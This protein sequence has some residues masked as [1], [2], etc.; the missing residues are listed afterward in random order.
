MEKE[1]KELYDKLLADAKAGGYHLS[2]DTEFVEQLL[3]GMLANGERYGYMACP[4]R[5]ASGSKEE[6]LDLICP[7]DYRDAD[8][9]EYDMCYCGLYVTERVLRQ[10]A[11]MQSIPDRRPPGGP[12]KGENLTR[13]V[14]ALPLPVYRCKVCGYLCAMEH[15]PER[16]PICK[17][18][19]DRFER[20]I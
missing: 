9:Q 5:L 3:A 10:E 7:C 14:G 15:P 16:C 12:H 8:L 1:I 13:G 19:A 17:V 18:T 6:D 20:F 2:P 4:C 11:E